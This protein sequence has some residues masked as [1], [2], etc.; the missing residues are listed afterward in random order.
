[1]ISL[2]SSVAGIR[3]GS[4]L[5]GQRFHPHLYEVWETGVGSLPPRQL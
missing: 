3:V 2:T 1:M 5:L 4:S